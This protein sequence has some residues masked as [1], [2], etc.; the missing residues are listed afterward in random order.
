MELE[1]PI[2][3]PLVED[4]LAARRAKRQ[5]I[6]AKHADITSTAASVGSGPGPS[7]ASQS[8]TPKPSSSVSKIAPETL[9]NDSYYHPTSVVQQST[10]VE[11]TSGY[12]EFCLSDC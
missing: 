10:P 6:L 11:T 2:S 7:S 1:L 3:P 8:P 5:A 4:I 12:V 9:R